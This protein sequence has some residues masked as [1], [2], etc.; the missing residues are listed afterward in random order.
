MSALRIGRIPEPADLS[1]R[2]DPMRR[3]D[4]RSI[5][6]IEEQVYPKPWTLGIFLSELRQRDTRCYVVARVNGD[7]VGYGGE[8][9]GAQ[10]AHVTNIAVD[11]RWH[12]LGLGSRVLAVL[13]RVAIDRGATGLTL[14]VRESNRA[15]QELYRRFG[16]AP[17][18]VRKRYYEQT[19]DAIVMWVHDIET[20]EFDERLSA[21]EASIAGTTVV[22]EGILNGRR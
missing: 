10:E 11:P 13:L 6:K 4:L 8:L 2:I 12:R 18:G 14:E 16:L 19:E 15:A 5:L 3:R 22:D 1:V 17:V 7:L 20:A 9:F 21:C